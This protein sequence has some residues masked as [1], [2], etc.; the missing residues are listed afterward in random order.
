VQEIQ[1][2]VFQTSSSNTPNQDNKSNV[3]QVIS[4]IQIVPSSEGACTLINL[5]PVLQQNVDFVDSS[6]ANPS[7]NQNNTGFTNII[8][9][10]QISSTIQSTDNESIQG[11]SRQ[12]GYDLLASLEAMPRIGNSVPGQPSIASDSPVSQA[13]IVLPGEGKPTVK[14]QHYLITK[15]VTNTPSGEQF[16]TESAVELPNLTQGTITDNKSNDGVFVYTPILN[17]PQGVIQTAS[18]TMTE[19]IDMSTDHL[20]STDVTPSQAD[21]AVNNCETPIVLDLTQQTAQMMAG[22]TTI[23]YQDNKTLLSN[24]DFVV[25]KESAKTQN[26][27]LTDS[28]FFIESACLNLPVTSA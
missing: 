15:I 12:H 14:V 16:E 2:A 22:S 23:G 7:Q 6:E 3:P 10:D 25:D 9:Q 18:S 24:V 19:K 5:P 17:I 8:D 27:L 13:K 1:G 21:P 20:K 26:Q 11:S 28:S 4:Q